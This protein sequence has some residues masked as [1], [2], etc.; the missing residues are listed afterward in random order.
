LHNLSY[1]TLSTSTL[2]KNIKTAMIPVMK[3]W[4]S[5]FV[6][7]AIGA[8]GLWPALSLA[9]TTQTSPTYSINESQIG[10][11]GDFNSQSTN[12]SF[13]PG[14]SD[15]GSTLGDSFIGNSASTNFQSNSGANTTFNPT[16]TFTVNTGSVN[17]G[18]LTQA[19]ASTGI[20]T[21]SVIDYTSYG[22]VV[23]VVG[24]GLKNGAYTMNSLAS[25]TAS[26][27]GTEQFGL[28]C[29]ANASPVAVG[30]DPIQSQNNTGTVIF[31]FGSAGTGVG[32]AYA[33]TG[34]YRFNSGETIASAPKSSGKTDYTATFLAN[35]SNTTP[36]G[37]YQA[38]I[39]LVATGTY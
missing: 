14:V 27:A 15:G 31:G 26:A 34:K 22:Y 17:L 25:D 24:T 33:Q 29:V 37:A 18:V 16:L 2:P 30:A 10:G 39:T 28:N 32:T 13:K 11:V 9:D 5:L 21:F 12:Y 8:L 7:G 36:G 3:W 6:V 23:T 4:R 35:I 38:G 19:A 20:A 1:Y